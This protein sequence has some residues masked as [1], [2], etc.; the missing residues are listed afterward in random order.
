MDPHQRMLRGRDGERAFARRWNFVDDPS[1]RSYAG[2][3]RWFQVPGHA[4]DFSGEF[5]GT[6]FRFPLRSEQ[7]A[8]HSELSKQTWSLERMRA[9]FQ[10]FQV[11]CK[12][13]LLFLKS[14][15][16][17][18]YWSE[19]ADGNTKLVF[20]A[21][22]NSCDFQGF[23]GTL[24]QMLARAARDSIKA[25]VQ[26]FLPKMQCTLLAEVCF[27]SNQKEN[28]N[29]WLVSSY[30]DNSEVMVF[31]EEKSQEVPGSR[32]IP[33]MLLALPVDETCEGSLF[34]FLQLPIKTGMSA[35]INGFFELS[36]NRRELW[37]GQ[38]LVGP[39]AVKRDWNKLLFSHLAPRCFLA[40]VKQLT[41]LRQSDQSMTCANG[42][43]QHSL[44]PMLVDFER[45]FFNL[46]LDANATELVETPAGPQQMSACFWIDERLAQDS[47]VV[48]ALNNLRAPI[49]IAGE[50]P[51]NHFRRLGKSFV[52]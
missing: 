42:F 45:N 5:D 8:H 38:D 15:S 47:A 18:E 12:P 41:R 33:W 9:V 1:I 24:R 34:C 22:V 14:V 3:V 17:V 21:S 51:R 39:E 29:Q 43:W 44:P 35:H 52:V 19:E 32:F 37:D 31:S 27:K 10:Q 23:Q 2:H 25:A 30:L 40:A 26:E 16:A 36:S 28:S 49:L 46:A 13:M 48:A 6:M 7:H 4:C 20:R 50:C 11:E